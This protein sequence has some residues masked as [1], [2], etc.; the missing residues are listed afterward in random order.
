M[1]ETARRERLQSLDSILDRLERLNLQESNRLPAELR[2][3]L[4]GAGVQVPARPNVSELIERV[5]ELQEEYLDR[6]EGVEP[7][8]LPARRPSFN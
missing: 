7:R 8:S 5:W 4:E 3:D 1:D 6:E 2:S